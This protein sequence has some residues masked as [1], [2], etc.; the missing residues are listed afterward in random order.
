MTPRCLLV[1]LCLAAAPAF[2]SDDPVDALKKGQPREVRQLIDRLVGCTHFAGEEG[3]DAER[4]REIESA[5]K[6]LRCD[7]LDRD[8]AA[9]LKRYAKQPATIRVLQQA[10]ALSQ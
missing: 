8:E 2:A 3:Y 6:E 7:R 9:A 5:M 10:R 1:F 4:R